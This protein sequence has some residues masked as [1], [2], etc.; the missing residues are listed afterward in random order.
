MHKIW[1]LIG[2]ILPIFLIGCNAVELPEPNIEDIDDD[3]K[4]DENIGDD[5]LMINCHTKEVMRIK[6]TETLSAKML[7][8]NADTC[9]NLEF[10]NNLVQMKDFNQ[11]A[12]LITSDIFISDFRELVPSWN[13]LLDNNSAVTFMIS[14]GNEAGYGDFYTMGYWK[15]NYKASF[16]SQKDEYASVFIDTVVTKYDN[17]DRLKIKV[18][19]KKTSTGATK[20]KNISITTK[21]IGSSNDFNFNHLN[22]KIIDVEPRQQLSI[23]SIGNIICSPTSLS[24]LMNYYGVTDSQDEVAGK[25]FDEGAKIY[26]NW[27]FNASYPGGFDNL[28]SRVEYIDSLSQVMAYLE[29]DT[30]LALSIKTNAK[31][32]L[33]GSIMGYSSGHLVVLIGVKQIDEVWYAVV[34]DPA[35]YTDESVEREYL[36]TELLDAWRGYVYVVSDGEFN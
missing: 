22:E 5:P 9:D 30:P 11:K 26:G 19:F 25:V 32:D 24:M 34:N 18:I 10:A 20:L 12:T 35:E 29:N 31:E 1:L 13:V 17:I 23:P 3:V 16:S 15:E 28:Y 27:S 8:E 21:S 2:V 7:W 14:V 36:L 33:V 4:E 6:S